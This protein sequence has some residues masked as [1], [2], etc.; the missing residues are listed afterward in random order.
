MK[1]C[2]AGTIEFKNLVNDKIHK[3][4]FLSKEK[5][6]KIT[7]TFM[8]NF[9]DLKLPLSE[10][11]QF[12]QEDRCKI[13]HYRSLQLSEVELFVN[14]LI[15]IIQKRSEDSIYVQA[16]GLGAYICLT[17]IVSN[18]LPKNKKYSFSLE[19]IPIKLFPKKFIKLK[20]PS[21]HISI[22]YF[23]KKDCWLRPF[24][25]LTTSPQYLKKISDLTVLNG[26]NILKRK[27]A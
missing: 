12:T 24:S 27:A 2:L 4:E 13:I 6:I 21:Y 8:N 17:A 18:L 14:Q 20:K 19:G 22:H 5:N 7:E 23:I 15:A 16:S 1:S 9:N 10:K 11:Q 26:P 3:H 25:T